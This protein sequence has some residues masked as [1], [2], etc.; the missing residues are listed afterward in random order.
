MGSHVSGIGPRNRMVK[1]ARQLVSL[2]GLGL[3]IL[4]VRM[5]Q[6]DPS[7]PAA[8]HPPTGSLPDAGTFAAIT[9]RVSFV[10]D[11][12][13]FEMHTEA[14]QTVRV[15]MFGIDAPEK[16]QDHSNRAR[17][18]LMARIH[19][20]RIEVRVIE[21]D[22]YGRFVGEVFRDGVSI[23]RAMVADGWAWHYARY[24]NDPALAQAERAARADR[25]GLWRG[26]QPVPP[27]EWRRSLN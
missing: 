26:R 16:G 17:E 12:D 5:R 14:G 9:G 8:I 1:R 23:N 21:T 6:P 19:R 3:L 4:L 13:S 15:R 7:P 10:A 22:S 27:W 25:R 11:G 24:S 18:A 2:L 20:R